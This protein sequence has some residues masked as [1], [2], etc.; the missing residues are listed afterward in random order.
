MLIAAEL[1]HSGSEELKIEDTLKA[2]EQ[3]ASSSED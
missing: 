3:S 2:F 1:S